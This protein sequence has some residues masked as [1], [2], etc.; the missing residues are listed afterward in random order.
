MILPSFSLGID[1]CS[2]NPTVKCFSSNVSDRVSGVKL[3]AALFSVRYLPTVV[4]AFDPGTQNDLSLISGGLLLHEIP[5][6]GVYPL[7]LKE[8]N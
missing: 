6:E 7:L 5:S 4:L 1:K 8:D 3:L 2:H